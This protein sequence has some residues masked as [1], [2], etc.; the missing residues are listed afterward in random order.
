MS[1]YILIDEGYSVTKETSLKDLESAVS[2]YYTVEGK[3]VTKSY[4]QKKLKS[5]HSTVRVY[6]YDESD[7]E[8]IKENGSC[9]KDWELLITRL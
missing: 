5:K 6:D 7:L 4:L 2:D 9:R 1:L 3:P 8:D